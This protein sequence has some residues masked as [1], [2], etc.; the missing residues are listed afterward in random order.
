MGRHGK[1]ME[2]QE[3]AV[4]RREEAEAREGHGQQGEFTERHGNPGIAQPQIM[5]A[6][7]KPWNAHEQA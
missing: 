7:R 2:R 6:N 3:Q 5:G 1:A 4:D